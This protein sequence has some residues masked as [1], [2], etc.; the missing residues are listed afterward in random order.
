MDRPC[1]ASKATHTCA[2]NSSKK[3][4]FRTN[5]FCNNSV[6]RGHP[7]HQASSPFRQTDWGTNVRT[8]CGLGVCVPLRK[9]ITAAAAARASPW[10][11]RRRNNPIWPEVG[12]KSASINPG[13]RRR[14]PANARRSIF[15]DAC[16]A[17]D[18]LQMLARETEDCLRR[19]WR[20][21]SGV[22]KF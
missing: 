16:C 9:L 17:L 11:R 8:L 10:R 18:N 22:W 7:L 13:R 15:R 6:A 21:F 14:A 1:V 2:G 20:N 12:K 4:L 19:K 5:V 3:I